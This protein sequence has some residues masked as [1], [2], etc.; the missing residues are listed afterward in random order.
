MVYYR[1]NT[2][3]QMFYL[4]TKLHTAT[5]DIKPNKI[6]NSVNTQPYYVTNEDIAYR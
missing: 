6:A 1:I 2:R 4:L 3:V 5:A